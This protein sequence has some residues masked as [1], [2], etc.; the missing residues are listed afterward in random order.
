M[1][2]LDTNVVVRL[3]AADDNEQS[4][5]VRTFIA[6]R[7]SRQPAYISSIVLA[8]AFWV[9]RRRLKYSAAAIE[10]GIRHLL[11]S[12]DIK[13]EHSSRL[14]SLFSGARPGGVDLVDYLVA[15]SAEAAGC[16][17]TVTFDRRAAASIPSMELLA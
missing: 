5:S 12:E 8:E 15:W 16:T 14:V 4:E 17:R 2:A 3:M 7:T 11:A 6:G 1:I 13:I 9:L 10:D